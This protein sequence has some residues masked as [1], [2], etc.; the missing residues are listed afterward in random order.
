MS[1]S[2]DLTPLQSLL[3][4]EPDVVTVGAELFADALRDQG[5]TVTSVEWRPPVGGTQ[6]ALATVIGDARREEANATALQRMLSAGAELVDVLPA[7]EALD[8]QP[9]SFLHAGPP[10][11]VDRASG[12]MLGA[13]MGAVLFEGLEEDAAAAE[14]ALR[15][16]STS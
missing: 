7:T 15:A 14:R 13:L 11:T 3:A 1:A 10:L 16:G 5:V 4:A 2:N 8:L 6:E 9:G 12:P